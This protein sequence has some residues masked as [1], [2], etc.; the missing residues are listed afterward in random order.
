[1]KN[2]A[3]VGAGPVGSY[4]AYLLSQKG[5]K[6]HLFDRK[7]QS[8]IG[9]PYQCTGLLTYDID[10]YFP[11]KKD[12]LI[13]TFSQI[14][15]ISPNQ[16]KLLLNKKEYLINRV[17]FDRYLFG[18]AL[19]QGT[20][21]YP[22]HQLLKLV[23]NKRGKANLIFKTKAGLKIFT[24]DLIIGADGPFSV[25]SRYLNHS[26]KNKFYFGL[27]AVVKGN[28][29]SNSYQV[30]F[31]RKICPCFFG[32]VV[33]ESKTRAR[34]GLAAFRHTSFHFG[35]FFRKIKVSPS[36]IIERQSGAIPLFN[37]KQKTVSRQIFLLGDAGGM[38][39]ATTLG[40]LVPAFRE[41]YRLAN[42]LSQKRKYCPDQKS[43]KLHLL[44]RK[45]LNRFTNQD[46]NTLF[47]LLSKPKNKAIIE[48]YSR[49]N[50]RQLIKKLILAEPR[51]LLFFRYLI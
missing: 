3:V 37:P 16:R 45:A 28:F 14:E 38:V 1:M 23:K 40:G 7:K 26:L 31:D 9:L 4:T 22:E 42:S 5:F 43:L 6:V 19:K 13:N 47:F 21:F 29:N 36:Q 51:L 46:Y 34:I 24:P 2:I 50:P 35:L 33:P 44:L 32:W 8:E 39:K 49:E 10:K 25:I 41:A 12:F 27:Q 11:L 15:L 48:K 18:L 30:Y 20:A 17:K